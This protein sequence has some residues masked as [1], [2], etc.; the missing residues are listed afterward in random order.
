ME[1]WHT[2]LLKFISILAELE[3]RLLGVMIYRIPLFALALICSGCLPMHW[4]DTPHLSGLVIDAAT[5]QPIAGARL[6]Y[7]KY[8]Q[9]EVYTGAD[10]RFDFPS[11]SHWGFIVLLPFDRLPPYSVLT[12]QASGYVATNKPY[13]AWPDHT[14]EVFHLSHQ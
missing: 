9:H 4:H 8:P 5:T 11:L 3:V 14:N 7:Y 1:V 12:V 13:F 10:G 2:Q 6:Q